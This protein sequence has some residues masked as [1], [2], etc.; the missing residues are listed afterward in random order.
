MRRFRIL[1]S[2]RWAFFAL[3]IV[4]VA[5]ATWW[6]GNWQFDRLE[7][8]RSSNAVVERN[9]NLEPAPV[10]EVLS[11][12]GDVAED[13]EW[14]VVTATGEYAVE[15]TVIVRYRTRD[16]EAGIEVVVPLITADGTALVV[17]RGWMPTDNRGGDAEGVPDPPSGELTITGYVRADGTGDS[18]RVVDGST[19]AVS[20]E[21]I[22]EAIGRPTYGGFVDLRSE[23]PEP[24]ETLTPRDLPEQNDG[25]HFFYGLQW[26]FFGVLAIFGFLYL[27]YDELKRGPHGQRGS[28]RPPRPKA[29]PRTGKRPPRPPR[30]PAQSARSAP[31]STGSITPE[32]NDAAGESRNAAARPNSSGRP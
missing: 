22:G 20:S 16:G 21:E 5:W 7:D 18:T 1:L 27:A 24:A 14:R 17:D 32:T 31:P 13:D 29:D 26:W 30:E 6:L 10:A 28:R 23:D 3:A 4:G 9:E 15:D 19:R 11:P 25:P 2:R 12:G 8:R